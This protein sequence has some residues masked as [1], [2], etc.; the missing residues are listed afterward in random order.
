MHYN[1]NS[2]SSVITQMLYFYKS[3]GGGKRTEQVDVCFYTAHT[4]QRQKN[5]KEKI[6]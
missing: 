3:E 1:V 5:K 6:K 2:L 4:H